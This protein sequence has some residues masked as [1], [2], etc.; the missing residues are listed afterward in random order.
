MKQFYQKKNEMSY[1]ESDD[2]DL[3]DYDLYPRRTSP[4]LNSSRSQGD[5]LYLSLFRQILFRNK[6][7]SVN[8]IKY[9]VLEKIGSGKFS[10]IYK[11]FMY[12]WD[13]LILRSRG[14]AWEVP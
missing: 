14:A 2:E 1:E 11:V 4:K 13:S 3:D 12:R 5:D 8:G 6:P 7:I 9:N 10:K